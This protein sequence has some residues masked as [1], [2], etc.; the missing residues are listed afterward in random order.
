MS[1]YPYI[2]LFYAIVMEIQNIKLICVIYYFIIHIDLYFINY[3]FLFMQ[4]NL[5]TNN[6]LF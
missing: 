1:I 6:L 4:E 2:K 3:I 5:L